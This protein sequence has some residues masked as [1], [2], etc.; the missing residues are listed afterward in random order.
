M[1]WLLLNVVIVDMELIET[2]VQPFLFKYSFDFNL[3]DRVDILERVGD[4]DTFA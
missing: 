3:V 2:G 1:F 4:Q